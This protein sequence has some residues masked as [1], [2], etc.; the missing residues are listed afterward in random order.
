MLVWIFEVDRM[1]K[2][3]IP[4]WGGDE[5][6]SSEVEIEQKVLFDVRPIAPAKVLILMRH[7]RRDL[8]RHG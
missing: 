2:E 6:M 7:G 5:G 4:G 1:D 8:E 3:P